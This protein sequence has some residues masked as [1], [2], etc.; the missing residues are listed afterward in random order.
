[1]R[2]KL[3]IWP[4]VMFCQACLADFAMVMLIG[5]GSLIVGGGIGVLTIK[6]AGP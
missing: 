4:Q 3:H 6:I 2:C 5:F 1:M